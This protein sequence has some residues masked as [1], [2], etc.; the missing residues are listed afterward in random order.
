MEGESRVGIEAGLREISLDI[1]DEF[2]GRNTSSLSHI[3]TA[4]TWRRR[5]HLRF[6][7]SNRTENSASSFGDLGLLSL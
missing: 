2:G 4:S 3:V 7:E 5:R 1:L 6:P